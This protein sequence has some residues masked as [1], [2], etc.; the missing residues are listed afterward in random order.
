MF[1][2]ILIPD[3]GSPLS[4]TAMQAA[5]EFA[6]DAG[7]KVTVLTVIEPYSI[8]TASPEQLESTRAEYERLSRTQAGNI[9]AA[10]EREA[11]RLGVPCEA[12][13]TESDDPYL[14]IIETAAQRG[15]D[16]IAMASHGR[17]GISALVLGS[18][19]QKVLTYSTVPVLVYR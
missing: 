17:R 3:D 6:R 14:A 11:K 7:A 15:C 16:L 19:A 8:F 2:H 13:Q 4:T 9:L 10:A 1:S 18:V 12:V 5:L